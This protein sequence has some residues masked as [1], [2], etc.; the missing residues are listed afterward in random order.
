[1]KQVKAPQKEDTHWGKSPPRGDLEKETRPSL[2][3]EGVS[4]AVEKRGRRECL[5]QLNGEKN[6]RKKGVAFFG[7][8]GKGSGTGP[9]KG[10]LRE[11]RK[12]LQIF[13]LKEKA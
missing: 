4:H 7:K 6:L 9:S 1:V 2:G 5:G 11:K 10:G 3:Y 12:V 13:V 8:K